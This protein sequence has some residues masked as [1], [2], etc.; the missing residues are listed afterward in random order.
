MSAPDR[1]DLASDLATLASVATRLHADRVAALTPEDPRI[2]SM[3]SIAAILDAARNHRAIGAVAVP[4]TAFRAD[5]ADTT[6]RATDRAL[7]R[8]RDQQAQETARALAAIAWHFDPVSPAIDTPQ[9][10]FCHTATLA[11]R[12]RIAAERAAPSTPTLPQSGRQRMP[13]AGP[14]FGAAA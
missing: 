2:A 1:P 8:S 6:R 5:L 10:V 9:I 14:L 7:A 13:A 3:A 12:A 4:W 11:I